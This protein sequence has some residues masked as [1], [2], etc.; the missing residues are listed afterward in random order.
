MPFTLKKY[1]AIKGKKIQ[2]IGY[3]ITTKHTSTSTRQSMY[4]GTFM[5][6][7]GQ[8]FDSVHF[9]VSAA[10]FPFRGRGFYKIEGKVSEEFD[11]Y[12]IEADRMEKLPIINKRDQIF[13]EEPPEQ[14]FNQHQ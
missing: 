1:T 3:L 13:R 9:P 8:T 12:T 7:E 4:F 6:A 14:I 10:R 11:V 2:I 5:D